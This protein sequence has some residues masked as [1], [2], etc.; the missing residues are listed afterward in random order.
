MK[1]KIK[2][3]LPFVLITLLISSCAINKGFE[4]LAQYDYFDA[5]QKFE[6]I[7]KRKTVAA[8]Y[9]LSLIY[10]RNDNP[11]HN[12]DSAL[13]KINAAYTGF[14]DLTKNEKE[15]YK[16]YG[17]DSLSILK[18]RSLI[19]TLYFKRAVETNSIYGFD[20]FISKNNWSS[21]I[22]KAIVLRDSLFFFENHEKGKA[23]DYELFMTTYPNSVYTSKADK[24]YNKAYFKEKTINNS[25][26]DYEQYI[27]DKPNG[28]FI[29]QAENSIFELATVN[30]SFDEYNSFIINYPDN[31]NVKKA[32]M[33]LFDRYTEDNYSFKDIEQF[34]VDYPDYPF[35]NRI[36]NELFMAN[37][38]FFKYKSNHKWGFISEEGNYYIEP[39]FDFVE[40][41]SEGLAVVTLNDKAGYI[42]K[43]NDTKIE[44]QFDDAYSFQNGFAVVEKNDLFGLI[45]RSGE[46]IVEPIFDDLGNV[47][48]GLFYFEKEGKKGFCNVKG[49]QVVFP[50][51]ADV[52][53]FKDNLAIVEKGNQV[54]VVD[55]N[56]NT[57][58]EISYSA[59]KMIQADLF[60]AKNDSAWGII[61]ILN[62]VILPFEYDFIELNTDSLLLVERGNEFNYWNIMKQE[63][64]TNVWYQSFSEYRVLAKFNNGFAKVKTIEGFNFIN[65]KGELVFE[66]FYS[67]LGGYNSYIGFESEEEWGYIDSLENVVVK[68]NYSK[69]YSFSENWGIVELN[70]KKGVIDKEGEILLPIYFE[71]IIKLNDSIVIA[72]QDNTYGILSNFTDSLIAYEYKLIEPISKSIVKI[73]SETEVTYYNFENNMWLKKEE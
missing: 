50:Q 5:K 57:K 14:S 12:I 18:H 6:R 24:L 3:I 34:L 23:K 2:I 71:E 4:S 21:D 69:V 48:D 38:D 37:I 11:F 22:N 61:N 63:F 29:A 26:N 30:K 9:G 65:K 25:I 17:L 43:T 68:P 53:N 59:I 62:E 42:T 15:K 32:W 27:I 66:K 28:D 44:P 60:A 67:N 46:Y 40:D 1:K 56:G 72:K 64:I 51:Y 10:Q 7:E 19:S 39:I 54:G 55:T 35:K 31:R 13:V 58:I 20:D 70:G 16:T 33:L 73:V 45:N 47:N 41:F 8:S 49:E 52:S 36:S